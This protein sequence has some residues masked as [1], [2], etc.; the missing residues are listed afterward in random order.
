MLCQIL[1]DK[2]RIRQLNAKCR[3]ATSRQISPD[4]KKMNLLL[5]YDNIY[6]EGLFRKER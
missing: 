4:S 6:I 1:E 3:R 2:G 5:C